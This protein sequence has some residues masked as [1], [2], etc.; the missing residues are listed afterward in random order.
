MH[1]QVSKINEMHDIEQQKQTTDDET[2][3]RL[4]GPAGGLL[5]TIDG[6]QARVLPFASYV[7]RRFACDLPIL[8]SHIFCTQ[9]AAP[10]V[11]ELA[12]RKAASRPFDKRRRRRAAAK[13]AKTEEQRRVQV[14]AEA[15]A[16]DYAESLQVAS[17]R[18][19]ISFRSLHVDL[20]DP[21][22]SR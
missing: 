11:A 10:T 4:P 9:D 7:C 17:Q 14:A 3:S 19:T 18:D 16:A 2:S 5:S 12:T 6:A 13:A 22:M 21:W 20:S 8:H 15:E 1:A